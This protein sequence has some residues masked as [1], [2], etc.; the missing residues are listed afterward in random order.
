MNDG[1]SYFQE[2]IVRRTLVKE[3][4][5]SLRHGEVVEL[6]YPESG[7]LR[8]RVRIWDEGR[9]AFVTTHFNDPVPALDL[10]ERIKNE[11]ERYHQVR[12]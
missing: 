5:Y 6:E 7:Q 2:P 9:D 10:L 8:Y 4:W 11:N 1:G 3:E 12:R